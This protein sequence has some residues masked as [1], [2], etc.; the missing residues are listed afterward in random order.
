VSWIEKV[1]KELQIGEE[2]IKEIKRFLKTFEVEDL[3]VSGKSLKLEEVLEKLPIYSIACNIGERDCYLVG[4]VTNNKPFISLELDVRVGGLEHIK[5][6]NKKPVETVEVES[7]RTRFSDRAL[8]VAQGI[9]KVFN[10]DIRV[11]Q[12]FF[13]DGGLE[14]ETLIVQL[15]NDVVE[16]VYNLV[17]QDC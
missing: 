13:E 14:S 5:I 12:I 9:A 16:I 4:Y 6:K 2:Q 3:K 7:A 17:P 11:S 15:P 10:G 1:E 8:M